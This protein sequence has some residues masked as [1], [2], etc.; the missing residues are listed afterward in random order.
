MTIPAEFTDDTKYDPD[1]RSVS[2]SLKPGSQFDVTT[3][4]TA[5][6]TVYKKYVGGIDAQQY[7]WLEISKPAVSTKAASMNYNYTFSLKDD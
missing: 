5:N 3:T 7:D 1:T 6:L 2:M 4:A